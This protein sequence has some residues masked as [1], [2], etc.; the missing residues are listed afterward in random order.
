MNW[1]V[2]YDFGKEQPAVGELAWPC[3]AGVV[4]GF[5]CAVLAKRLG[6]SEHEITK[7]RVGGILVG[8]FAIVF[9]AG[10]IPSRVA[11]FS[12]MKE[13]YNSRT[14]REVEGVVDEFFPMP[15]GGHI[16]ES[17]IVGKVKFEYSDYADFGYGFNNT[18]SHGG[19]IDQG[20]V[21]RIWYT[22]VGE[23]NIIL[24]LEIRE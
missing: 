14:Y 12:Q 5:G 21:V 9:A 15:H 20:K 7:Y 3:A 16:D 10:T 23:R 11:G 8:A 13:I 4:L 18:K 17:F 2:A 1:R 22:P 24:R 19:P 6:E